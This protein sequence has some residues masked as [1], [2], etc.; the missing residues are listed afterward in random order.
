MPRELVLVVDNSGSM[1]GTSMQQA[2][3]AVDRALSR[4]RPDDRFNV[5]RFDHTFESVFEQSVPASEANVAVARRFVQALRASGGTELLAP[6]A[7]ALS[8]PPVP[9]H[10]RQVVLITDAGIGS[11]QMVLDHIERHLGQARLFAVG[12]GSAPNE[13]FLR[14]AVELGRGSQVVVRALHLV[15]SQT[16]LLLARLDQPALRDLGLTWPAPAEVFPQRL[17]DLYVGEPLQVLA[18]LPALTGGLRVQGNG[19]AQA[20]RTQVALAG[21]RPAEGV[22]RL[23]AR[24]KVAALEDE[25]RRGGDEDVVRST[26]LPLALRHGLASRWTSLVAVER[27]PVRPA[28]SDLA[29]VAFANAAPAGTLALAQGA[30]DARQRLAIALLLLFAAALA[31]GRRR[32]QSPIPAGGLSHGALANGSRTKRAAAAA[33]A[34][35]RLRTGRRW[36][37]TAL[38]AAAL[39]AAGT[40]L[41]GQLPAPPA[42]RHRARLVAAVSAVAVSPGPRI[43]LPASAGRNAG[44]GAAGAASGAVPHGTGRGAGALRRLR[45]LLAALLG[46]AALALAADAGWIHAK[47]ALAQWLLERSW[48]QGLAQGEAP[49]PWPWADTRPVAR[50]LRPDGGMQIVLAGDSGRVLAF[51]PGW[52]RPAR[53]PASP[54]PR[55]SAAIAI[56]TSPGCGSS[57]RATASASKA[58]SR[59][60]TTSCGRRAWSTAGPPGSPSMARPAIACCWSPAG[61]STRS[62]PAARCATWSRRFPQIPCRRRPHRCRRRC[63]PP[64]AAVVRRGGWRASPPWRTPTRSRRR[65]SPGRAARRARGRCRS[66]LRA[67]SAQHPSRS[68]RCQDRGRAGRAAGR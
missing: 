49:P 58:A 2:A 16:D 47:A 25:L 18:K 68:P 48:Q 20:W 39:A 15:D 40:D 10:L 43:P 3:A 9:G 61:R 57:S 45:L 27:V 22:G 1:S 23:W 29:S 53:R 55:W 35:G 31:L 28:E 26:A 36:P 41:A 65:R 13:H 42:A 46:L 19:R 51:G 17:P 12:I 50:L 4:L 59:A 52:A 56:P 34:P 8:A 21:A 33:A 60:A 14:R 67:G 66:C 38:P 6:L 11:E 30:T 44:A 64:D 5:I 7:Q 63:R 62:A 32:Q 24:A 54:A 37:A